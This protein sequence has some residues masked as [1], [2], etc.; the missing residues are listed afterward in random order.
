MTYRERVMN[1]L[2]FKPVD[3]PAVETTYA[4][5]GF[6]EHGEKMNALLEKYPGDFGPYARQVIPVLPPEAFDENGRYYEKKTDEWGTVTEYRVYGIRGHA[7]EFPVVTDEDADKYRFPA[8]PAVFTDAALCKQYVDGIKKDYFSLIGTGGTI[9]ERM[10]AI[11]GFEQH[12][13]DLADDNEAINRL[14]DRMTEYFR[15]R[16]AALAEAGAEGVSVSDDFGTQNGLLI[17]RDTFRRVLKPRFKRMLE[18][19]VQA[20]M[21]IHFHSCGRVID[22]FDDLRDLGVGS[23]WPQ[24]PAYDMHEL[25]DA[26]KY[27]GFSLAIHT[28]RANTMTNGTPEQVRD[29]ILLEN[30]IFKPKDGGSWFYYECDT[31][32]PFENILAFFETVYSL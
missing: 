26:L 9:L 22:L 28:D 21:H 11:R 4:T 24:L 32:F 7:S 16:I 13:I 18:P 6:Y 25:R 5:V 10:W 23:I 8:Q 14:M 2:A 20:G 30:E 1:V 27:Y 29:L 12:M 15:E 17:S 19:A 31:G 3:K